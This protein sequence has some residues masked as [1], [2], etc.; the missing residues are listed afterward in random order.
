MPSGRAFRFECGRGSKEA[1]RGAAE[2]KLHN[3]MRSSE[4]SK[5]RWARWREAKARGETLGARVGRPPNASPSPSPSPSPAPPAPASESAEQLRA[6]LI[7]LGDAQPIDPDAVIPPSDGGGAGARDDDPP[8]DDEG[9]ELIA[10]L[11]AKAATVGLVAFVNSRLKKR[12][13]PQH[14][15]PHEKGLEWYHD[16]MEFHLRRLLGKTATLGPTGKIF[17]GAA[18]IVGSMLM[19]AEPIDPPPPGQPQQQAAPDPPSEAQPEPAPPAPPAH[20]NGTA[21]ARRSALGVF[22]VEKRTAN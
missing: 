13:P 4:G 3:K 7:G 18:I 8:M 17:A 15:E 5:E 2:S 21:L 11:V 19:N 20:S 22:G 6:K 12:K 9:G 14:A 16:G 10:S 1:A